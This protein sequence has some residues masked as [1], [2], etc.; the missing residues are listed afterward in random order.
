MY[1]HDIMLMYSDFPVWSLIYSSN[2]VAGVFMLPGL[3]F[4]FVPF[5]NYTL[6][7]G[8]WKIHLIKAAIV[9]SN[10]NDAFQ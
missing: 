9:I 3:A 5:Q 10:T 7:L 2:T 4:M 1:S 8:L 6:Q